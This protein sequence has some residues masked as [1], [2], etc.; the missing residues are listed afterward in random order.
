MQRSTLTV[1]AIHNGEL[2]QS[3]AIE[4]INLIRP[5]ATQVRD[6]SD[7]EPFTAVPDVND[8][9]R[10]RR[11]QARLETQWAAHLGRPKN[12]LVSTI[13]RSA[14]TVSTTVSATARKDAWFARQ[15]EKAVTAKHIQAWSDFHS[16][17]LSEL[18]VLESD[19]VLTP[20]T[21]TSIESILEKPSSR[22]RYV[23]L[24]GGLEGAQIAINAVPHARCDQDNTYLAYARPVTNTSCAYMINSPMAAFL[25]AFLEQQPDASALGIDWLFNAAFLNSTKVE[26]ECLHAAPPVIN[27]G[28]ITGATKSWH[29]RR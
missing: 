17:G 27:H 24:A 18:L 14:F 10:W 22:A 6:V 7:Q 1:A 3:P 2:Q 11:E 29:P 5:I 16:S 9:R 13:G 15:V 28:S 12:P 23:N 8:L 25:V 19:A 4:V 21:V 20:R 26:I